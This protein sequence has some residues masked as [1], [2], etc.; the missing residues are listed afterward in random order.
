MVR[1]FH[2]GSMKKF[3]IAIHGGAGQLPFWGMNKEREKQYLGA[4]ESCLD[5]GLAVLSS[6]GSSVMAVRTAIEALEDNPLFN[7]GRG[8]TINRECHVEMDAAIMD[9]RTLRAGACSAVRGVKN[10]IR[11][12]WTIMNRCEHLYLTGDGAIDFAEEQGLEFRPKKYFITEERYEK[13]KSVRSTAPEL[14]DKAEGG[15]AGAVAIDMNGDLAA[16]TSTGGLTNKRKGRVGD[17]PIIGAGTYANNSTCAVSCTGV[18][19]YI[20]RR[21]TAHE[22][23]SI[24]CHRHWSLNDACDFIIEEEIGRMGGKFGVIA[25]D[26]NYN[27]KCVFNTPRMYRAWATSDGVREARVF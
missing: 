2:A 15:T 7:A 27:V 25:I 18:G 20:I 10:P 4:L 21:V 9:G 26:K 14:T 22:I 19:E 16:G 12:S 17:S 11:L 1:F 13:W 24:M 5:A 8:S 23:H 6:G 3:A